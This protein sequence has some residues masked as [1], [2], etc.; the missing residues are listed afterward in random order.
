[1][2]AFAKF[3]LDNSALVTLGLA[4]AAVLVYVF[5]VQPNLSAHCDECGWDGKRKDLRD[6]TATLHCPQCDEEVV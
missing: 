1:M 3:L 2:E 4:V 5:L 6:D